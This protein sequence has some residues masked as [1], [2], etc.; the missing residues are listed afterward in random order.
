MG[1]RSRVALDMVEPIMAPDMVIRAMV[2]RDT[3]A[4]R[5]AIQDME[6]TDMEIMDM[7]TTLDTIRA[8]MAPTMEQIMANM[9]NFQTYATIDCFDSLVCVCIRCKRR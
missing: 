1:Q 8:A 5:T 7:A 2:T 3:Q 6:E 9:V 4:A